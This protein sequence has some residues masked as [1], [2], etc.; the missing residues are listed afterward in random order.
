MRV[1]ILCEDS[2]GAMFFKRFIERLKNEGYLKTNLT[3][4]ADRLAG[5]CNPKIE[6][7]IKA[8]SHYNKIIL[9]ADAHVKPI[10]EVEFSLNQHIP[11]ELINR[12]FKVVFPLEIEEWICSSL[13]I[14][15]L[16]DKPSKILR[17]KIGY[18]KYKL[19]NFADTLD[20]YKLGKKPNFHSAPTNIK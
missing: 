7:Q 18:E 15:H 16:Y 11:K 6:R 20:L 5:I 4:G 10:N 17:N 1:F 8:S 9:V 14:M 12:V 19:P 2:Y 3:I 13:N